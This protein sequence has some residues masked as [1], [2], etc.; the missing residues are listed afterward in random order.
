MFIDKSD[1][2]L[3]W[4][5]ELADLTPEQLTKLSEQARAKAFP[6]GDPAEIEAAKR[7]AEAIALV[8]ET[9]Q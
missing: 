6:D 1:S 7:E 3:K 4:S 5:G 8:S 9:V 2:S